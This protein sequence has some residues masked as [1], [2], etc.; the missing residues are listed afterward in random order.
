[1]TF[2]LIVDDL[3]EQSPRGLAFAEGK[4]VYYAPPSR[5]TMIEAVANWANKP[6]DP[7]QRA[8]VE[9]AQW[10]MSA[11][12]LADRAAT[13]AVFAGRSYG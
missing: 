3:L 2:S 5:D 1:M 11:E 4:M 12:D 8:I 6:F 13:D 10:G 9:R 7:V